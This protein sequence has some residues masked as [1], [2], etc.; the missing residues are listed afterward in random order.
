ML[1]PT[2]LQI[3]S[4][5]SLAGDI[6]WECF[7]GWLEESLKE[8][9]ITNCT[10]T[11]EITIKNQGRCLELKEILNHIS[12]TSNYLQNFRNSDIINKQGGVR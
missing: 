5:V 7:V 9:A 3:R 12:N 4:L 10:S 8:Q 1:K 6:N 11:G 2:E